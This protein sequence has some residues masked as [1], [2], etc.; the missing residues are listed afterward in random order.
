VKPRTN[1]L[2]GADAPTA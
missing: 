2:V 1:L